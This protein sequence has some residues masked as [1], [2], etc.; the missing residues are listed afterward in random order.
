MEVI[1]LTIVR[2]DEERRA[3]LGEPSREVDPL[4]SYQMFTV[5]EMDLLGLLLVRPRPAGTS[6]GG[7][8]S[9]LRH[10]TV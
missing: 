7:S 9:G 10:V 4:L 8:L 6:A 1:E 2:E 5:L 3:C